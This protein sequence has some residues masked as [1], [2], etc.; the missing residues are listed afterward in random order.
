MVDGKDIEFN[1]K[2]KMSHELQIKLLRRSIRVSNR[3]GVQALK[4]KMGELS[5]IFK[6]ASLLKEA[7]PLFLV[8]NKASFPY[9]KG[10][11]T[12]LLDPKLGLV[13]DFKKGD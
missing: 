5:P 11:V 10:N 6:D 2:Q 1:L 12:F 13:I 4:S 7:L 3:R 8:E 9:E